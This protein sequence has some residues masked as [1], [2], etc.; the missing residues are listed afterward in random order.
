I[1]QDVMKIFPNLVYHNINKERNLDVYTMNYSGFG[2]IAIKGIQELVENSTKQQDEI[3]L[4]KDKITKLENI[5]EKLAPA[6]FQNVTTA[7]LEQNSPNPAKNSTSIGYSLPTNNNSAQLQIMDNL[8]RT[9]KT[10]PLNSSGR[11]NLDLSSLSTG[12]YTYSLVI[13]GKVVETKKLVKANE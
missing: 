4:L 7:T 10:I 5:I 9:V 6:Q 8:G 2:V 12:N 1:A 13:D 3:Q 11:I